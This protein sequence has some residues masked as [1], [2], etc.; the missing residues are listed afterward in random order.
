MQAAAIVVQSGADA[1]CWKCSGVWRCGNA[2][3]EEPAGRS[4]AHGSEER[5]MQLQ[6]CCT[7]ATGSECGLLR[8]CTKALLRKWSPQ[9]GVQRLVM[10]IGMDLQYRRQPA[11]DAACCRAPTGESTAAQTKPAR[12]GVRCRASADPHLTANAGRCELNS[13]A[14]MRTAALLSESIAAQMEPEGRSE[15][16]GN[17]ERYG[18]GCRSRLTAQKATCCGCSLLP[19]PS[20]RKH[21]LHKRSPPGLECGAGQVLS[22]I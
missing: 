20:G 3:Q 15:A 1:D 8:C 6:T 17:A 16:L 22:L 11:A 4:A 12:A 7:R 19:C 18:V 21:L 5:Q 14:R 13:W 10:L 9:G 2:V